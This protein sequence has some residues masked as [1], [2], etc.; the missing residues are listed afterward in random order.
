MNEVSEKEN[1]KIAP[2]TF[3]I[4]HMYFYKVPNLTQNSSLNSK[5]STCDK[6]EIKGVRP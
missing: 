6:F 1:H 3:D 4:C 5:L 2:C